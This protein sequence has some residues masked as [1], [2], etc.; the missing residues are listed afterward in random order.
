MVRV[1]AMAAR[2]RAIRPVRRRMVR[3]LR[4]AGAPPPVS[5]GAGSAVVVSGTGVGVIVGDGVDVGVGRTRTKG[6]K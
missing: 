2:A 1:R 4:L 3:A 6:L 5:G